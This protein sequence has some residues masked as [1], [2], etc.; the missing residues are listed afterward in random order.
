MDVIIQV[1]DVSNNR[2]IYT[3][4]LQIIMHDLRIMPALIYTYYI[5]MNERALIR[6]PDAYHTWEAFF[7]L[8]GIFL[9]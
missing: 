3:F 4:K 9:L 7:T 8:Q 6:R 5:N 1:A 2:C